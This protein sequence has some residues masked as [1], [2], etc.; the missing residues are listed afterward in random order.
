MASSCSRVGRTHELR[1][2]ENVLAVVFRAW[3]MICLMSWK[4]R[5]VVIFGCADD[6][7]REKK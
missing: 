6:E 5:L 7:R 3:K 2:L 1:R 4:R